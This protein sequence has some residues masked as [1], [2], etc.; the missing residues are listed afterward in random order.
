MR[1]IP[2]PVHVL[3]GHLVLLTAPVA[4]LMSLAYALLPRTRGALRWP[5]LAAVALNC[6]LAIWAAGAGSELYRQL[7]TAPGTPAQAHAKAGDWLAVASVSVALLS[8]ALVFWRLAPRRPASGVGHAA[9]V[10]VLTVSAVAVGSTTVST[11][12]PALESVWSHHE[13]WTAQ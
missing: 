1:E 5:L 4:T 3:A 7:V 10:A 11:L 2:M 13:I 8:L 9:A 6:A 12:I